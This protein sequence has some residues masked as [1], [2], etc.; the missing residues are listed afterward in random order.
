MMELSRAETYCLRYD[1]PAPHE[2]PSGEVR[3]QEWQHHHLGHGDETDPEARNNRHAGIVG[4]AVPG[5]GVHLDGHGD[6]HSCQ[7]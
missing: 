7:D 3:R 4:P 6:C 2:P 5:Q 1:W